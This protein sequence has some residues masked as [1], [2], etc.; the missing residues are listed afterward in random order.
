VR[1]G[2]AT[3]DAVADAAAEMLPA[4]RAIDPRASLVIQQQ[5][6]SG[7]EVI[8]GATRDPKFGPLLMF[9]LGGIF[10]EVMKDVVF[11]VHP[12]SDADAHD[13]IRAV[14]GFALLDGAR[15]RP[16]A[17]LAALEAIILRLA[18]LMARCPAIAELDVNPLFAATAGELTAA[19][20]ARISL[21][22]PG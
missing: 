13:M 18:D 6:Q 15:G 21:I 11:R 17:D 3:A 2:L 7:T 22:T 20:D 1:V 8:L 19:A 9:G 10:V 12:V 4:A 16:R 5:A 14:K